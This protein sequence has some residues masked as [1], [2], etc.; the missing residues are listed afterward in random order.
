MT[1]NTDIME[2]KDLNIATNKDF[3]VIVYHRQCPDGILSQYCAWKY[4]NEIVQIGTG[5]GEDPIGDFEN[6]RIVFIDVSPTNNFII[7]NITKV[8][9][10]TV[11]DHHKSASDN[12]IKFKELYDTFDN[13]N[14][15]YDM[16]RSGCQMAWDYFFENETR[17]WFIDYV[18]DRDLWLWR[19][20]N[21]KEICEVMHHNGW[22]YTDDI[23]TIDKLLDIDPKD[24]ISDG[25]LILSVKDKI[26]EN[27]IKGA[28]ESVFI[29]NN[30]EDPIKKS[31]RIWTG[32]TAY[33]F[34]S[35]YGNKLTERKFIDGT[36]PDFV[37][38][39]FYDPSDRIFYTSL[40]GG[41]ESPDLSIISRLYGG[42][43]HAKAS[44]IQLDADTFN[45][46]IKF[47]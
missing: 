29:I 32:T 16:D 35:D 4:N 17:P 6:K 39:Y 21:S 10:I 18:G 14:V 13:F 19:L 42:G 37:V 28:K 2:N 30:A 9:S 24:L 15:I 31:Y 5:A 23:S 20:P 34:R 46:T 8:T 40:R 3:D 43:G 44:G 25:K 36:L 12:Y 7:T 11:L 22:L 33:T 26:L 45:N 1:N 27:E 47:V 41:S 38:I